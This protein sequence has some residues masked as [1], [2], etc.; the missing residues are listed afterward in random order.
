MHILKIPEKHFLK[1]QQYAVSAFGEEWGEARST[2]FTALLLHY[3]P[4]S[5][6]FVSNMWGFNQYFEWYNA[7]SFP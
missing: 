6:C 7:R 4:F 2:L 5:V 3:I 1:K